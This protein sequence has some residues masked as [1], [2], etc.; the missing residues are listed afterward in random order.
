MLLFGCFD[1]NYYKSKRRKCTG[2]SGKFRKN[3]LK[4][5]FALMLLKNRAKTRK[6]KKKRGIGNLNQNFDL[7]F[8]N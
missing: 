7:D 1:I 5:F 8:L 2:V 4:R 6:S 3:F